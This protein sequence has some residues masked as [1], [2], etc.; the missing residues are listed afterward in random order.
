MV[1][2]TI[3]AV[4]EVIDFFN[5]EFR[6]K[7]RSADE[8]TILGDNLKALSTIRNYF[9]VHKSLFPNYIPICRIAKRINFSGESAYELNVSF[10]RTY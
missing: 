5:D 6:V 8:I 4:H 1:R 2:T 9:K 7:D 10:D 3:D